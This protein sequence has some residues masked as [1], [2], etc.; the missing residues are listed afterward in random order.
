[1]SKATTLWVRRKAMRECKAKDPV[2]WG[3]ISPGEQGTPTHSHRDKHYHR[4]PDQHATKPAGRIYT[5]VDVVIKATM[6]QIYTA[7]G[8]R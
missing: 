8:S 5:E 7:G 3:R 2:S 4:G 6:M 1:M